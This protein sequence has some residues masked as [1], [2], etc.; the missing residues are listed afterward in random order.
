[1]AQDGAALR[2]TIIQVANVISGRIAAIR[3]ALVRLNRE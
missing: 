1:M 2:R 3:L